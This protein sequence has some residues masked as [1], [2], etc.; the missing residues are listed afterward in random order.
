MIRL[1]DTEGNFGGHSTKGTRISL[2][3]NCLVEAKDPPVGD[4]I[5]ASTVCEQSQ[6]GGSNGTNTFISLTDKMVIKS[7]TPGS[8]PLRHT[9]DGDSK[10]LA[11]AA[12]PPKKH[13]PRFSE[14]VRRVFQNFRLFNIHFHR[15]GGH[16]KDDYEDS[17]QYPAATVPAVQI[18]AKTTVPAEKSTNSQLSQ[19]T[20]KPIDNSNE[21]TEMN[22]LI[23]AYFATSPEL[24][25]LESKVF[26]P[27]NHRPSIFELPNLDISHAANSDTLLENSITSGS[28]AGTPCVPSRASWRVS[29][30]EAVVKSILKK[31]RSPHVVF[32]SPLLQPDGSPVTK[33]VRYTL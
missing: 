16:L 21:E 14:N 32:A 18:A 23:N 15:C 30:T 17:L 9:R 12:A 6:H 5:P 13:K 10:Y 19:A 7:L 26:S 24:K 3:D 31:T 28:M 33:R 2:G 22:R 11:M 27:N 25:Q 1:I 8:I 4:T 29:N 20:T